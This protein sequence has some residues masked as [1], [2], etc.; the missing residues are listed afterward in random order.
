[1]SELGIID[2]RKIKFR[3]KFAQFCKHTN[4]L[5]IASGYFYVSGFELV[6]DDLSDIKSIKIVMGN[7]TDPETAQELALGHKERFERELISDLNSI[8]DED[9]N[10]IKALEKLHDYIREG[11]IDI[12]I[13]TKEKF[14]AKAY[15]FERNDGSIGDVAVVGSSNFTRMGLGGNTELNSIH[16]NTAELNELKEWYKVIWK[17]A[18]PYKDELLK[19][20]ENSGPFIRNILGDKEFIT[21]LELLKCLIY[22]FLYHDVTTFRDI[23]AEFQRIG[24]ENAKQKINTFNGCIISDSVGLGKTFIGSALVEFYQKQGEN[25]L[26]IVP[27]SL[28]ENW[29]RE[30]TRKDHNGKRFFNVSTSDSK[31][32]VLSISELSRIDLTTKAGIQRINDIRN[33]YGVILIDEAHRLRNHGSFDDVKNE[34]SGNK[35]Y[36]NIQELKKGIAKRYILLTATPL[37]NSIIDLRN[38]VNIFTNKIILKNNGLEFSDFDNYDQTLRKIKNLE[39]ENKESNLSKLSDL[40]VKLDTHTKGVIKILEDVM[41]LRTRSDINERYPDLTIQG[42]RITFK[43]AEVKPQKY[44]FPKTYLSIYENISDFLVNLKVPHIA[45]IN[46]SSGGILAGLYRVLLFKR[47]ESSIYSFVKSLERLQSKEQDFLSEIKKEGWEKVRERR[48]KDVTAKEEALERDEEILDWIEIEN[49]E[50]KQE[51]NSISQDEVVEMIND[52][53]KSIKEFM[54]GFI[55]EIKI[56]KD[57][58]SYDDPKLTKLREILRENK[59]NKVLIFTQYI[60]TVNYLYYHIKDIY[61]LSVDC[62]TGNEEIGTSLDRTQK[63]KLFAPKA[64]QYNLKIGEREIDFLISTDALSEGVNLQDANQVINYD[65]PWNPMRIVQRIGR[66][67][68]IGSESRTRVYNV[69]PDEELEALLKLLDKLQTRIKTIS[70]IIGKENYILSDEEEINPKIIGEKIKSLRETDSVKTYEEV[71]RN[72]ILQSL[73]TTDDHAQ[74]VLEL[75]ALIDSLGFEEVEF[76]KFDDFT[77]LP[78]SIMK[79]EHRKGTFIMFRIFDKKRSDEPLNG[80]LKDII[81]FKDLRTGEILE[82][83]IKELNINDKLNHLKKKDVKIDLDSPLKELE[84]YFRKKILE[85]IKKSYVPTK[86][87]FKEKQSKLQSFIARRLRG[88]VVNKKLSGETL[89]D[90]DKDQAKKMKNRYTERVISLKE[91]EKL[92]SY[93]LGEKAKSRDIQAVISELNRLNDSEFIRLLRRFYR[94]F[95]IEEEEYKTKLR[96]PTDINYQK[97]CWGAFI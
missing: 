65:L 35:N 63:V 54:D 25:I 48:K 86:M 5:K 50:E 68:R 90:S 43:M 49:K 9:K 59:T 45:L 29:E 66:V 51:I 31:L 23:L 24:V 83:N 93:I 6:K 10:K 19:I 95:L 61:D 82:K 73:K 58:F 27:A 74:Q 16:R 91:M 75:K 8:S 69:F 18:E 81:L 72:P 78:Y 3:E 34:Y 11:K 47:L 57:E 28:K 14:H 1:M 7:E 40:R 33:K 41:I 53:L 92:K 21:P 30:L 26:L 52:D 71:G 12:K 94:N 55:H 13:Y 36:A 39:K 22:E 38:I 79:N 87:R 60:D 67:D 32:N 84:E 70:E 80:K 44:T 15:I 56:G 64:N 97:V 76:K 77:G 2:N 88:I 46:E 17:E 96:D 85:S 62:V 37:N 42:K 4:D 20:I 89:T